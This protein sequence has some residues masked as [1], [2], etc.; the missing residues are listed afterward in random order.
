M[1]K[2]LHKLSL[3]EIRLI[4]HTLYEHFDSKFPEKSEI[5]KAK[6]AESLTEDIINNFEFNLG[7]DAIRDRQSTMLEGAIEFPNTWPTSRKIRG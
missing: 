7:L 5:G 6:L 4:T 1:E 2:D 3:R